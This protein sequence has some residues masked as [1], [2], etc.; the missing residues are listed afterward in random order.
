M[1]VLVYYDFYSLCSC[2]EYVCIFIYK[3]LMFCILLFIKFYLSIDH[4]YEPSVAGIV[5]IAN[6]LKNQQNYGHQLSERLACFFT[7]C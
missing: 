5:V 4:F 3:L 7:I 1:V 6:R 2:F